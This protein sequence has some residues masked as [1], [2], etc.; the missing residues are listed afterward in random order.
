MPAPP[1]D[2]FHRKIDY[3]RLSITD[4]CNL[5]CSYCMPASGVVKL[6]HTE[7]LRYEEIVRLVRIAVSIGISKI[8]ITGGEP[9]VRKDAL[10]LC[11]SI[12]EVP[13]LRG[14]SITTNGVLLSDFAVELLDAGIRRINV[15]LDT[16]KPERFAKI[17]GKDFFSRVWA[18]IMAAEK[19]GISPV[20]LNAV[21]LRG[22]NDDEIEDLARLTFQFPFH[23]RFIE[24]MPFRFELDYQPVFVPASEILERLRR[25]AP[26]EVSSVGEGNGPALYYRF[27]GA[28][29]KIGIIS[30]V[31]GHFCPS[32]NRLRVTSDGKIRTC[33]FSSDETDLR[34]PLRQGASN[35]EIAAAML[36]AIN[37]KPEKHHLSSSVFCNR[38]SR[39]MFSI[40]G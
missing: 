22:V 7:I 4:R 30:P 1:T 11:A 31:S 23:V 29:G 28:L 8:R 14:L 15:S 35:E 24:F 37:K 13:G 3:L 2:S 12:S 32:C 20:K 17:T 16:L 27:Q 6:D 33:L 38:V 9:L 26:L 19:A 36:T 25:L 10:R 21:I 39:P 40:G 5:R 18:G 34:G